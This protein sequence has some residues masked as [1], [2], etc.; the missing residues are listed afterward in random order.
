MAIIRKHTNPALAA[1]LEKLADMQNTV[2]LAIAGDLSAMDDILTEWPC[3][4]NNELSA[5]CHAVCTAVQYDDDDAA[6]AEYDELR[7]LMAEQ[8]EAARQ[9]WVDA[10]ESIIDR[11]IQANL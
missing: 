6:N 3:P 4:C 2:K 8:E 9:D 7:A 1:L 10:C 11:R 5:A